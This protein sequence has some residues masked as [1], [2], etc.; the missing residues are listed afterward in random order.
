MTG[1][2]TIVAGSTIIPPYNYTKYTW[3]N[4]DH[5]EDT[6][7]ATGDITVSIDVGSALNPGDGKLYVIAG[8][9]GD[10][11][12]TES[13]NITSYELGP[14]PVFMSIRSYNNPIRNHQSFAWHLD[15]QGTELAGTVDLVL[16]KTAAAD[17]IGVEVWVM[18]YDLDAPPTLP[19]QMTFSGV[20]FGNGSGTAVITVTNEAPVS[21][22]GFGWFGE[23]IADD[24]DET[25]T[26]SWSNA[27]EDSDWPHQDA[28][29]GWTASVALGQTGSVPQPTRTGTASANWQRLPFL[30]SDGATAASEVNTSTG[31]S[32]TD[33]SAGASSSS[34]TLPSGMSNGDDLFVYVLFDSTTSFVYDEV[35]L[36]ATGGTPAKMSVQHQSGRQ[37]AAMFHLRQVSALSGVTFNNDHA[38]VAIQNYQYFCVAVSNTR[39]FAFDNYQYSVVSSQ[40]NSQNINVGAWAVA[41]SASIAYAMIGCVGTTIT[42]ADPSGWT[43]IQSSSLSEMDAHFYRQTNIAQNQAIGSV[44]FAGSSSGNRSDWLVIW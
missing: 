29:E 13:P 43:L 28:T 21:W 15:E 32:D 1:V 20:Q 6:S 37:G 40:S 2:Q 34:F 3:V 17:W 14:S 9:T 24:G 19:D 41:P 18:Y 38:S 25:D 12:D 10:F 23:A 44:S 31:G 42:G 26:W 39:G 33:L 30:F 5:V 16:G 35:S 4:T 11:D 8:I 27:T 36:S 22:D 7:N